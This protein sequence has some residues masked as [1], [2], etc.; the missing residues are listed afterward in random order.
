M[1]LNTEIEKHLIIF[2]DKL[3]ELKTTAVPQSLI[4][5][6]TGHSGSRLMSHD[7]INALWKEYFREF[8]KKYFRHDLHIYI[9]NSF[10]VSICTFCNWQSLPLSPSGNLNNKGM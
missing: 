8:D 5:F 4:Q 3:R 1:S 7:D 6:D 10:C 2:E 9:H